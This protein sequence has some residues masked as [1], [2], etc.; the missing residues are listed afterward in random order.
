MF[1]KKAGAGLAVLMGNFDK[2]ESKYPALT[3]AG[4]NFASNWNTQSQTM[5]QKWKNLT[6]G[7]EALAIK[8]G[9]R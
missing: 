9:R 6:N 5:E 8:F 7:M 3:A 1:G 2:L 4:N